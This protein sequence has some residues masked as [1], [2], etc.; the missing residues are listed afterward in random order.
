MLV[1]L[2]PPYGPSATAGPAVAEHLDH[3][4][5]NDGADEGDDNLLPQF[6]R[7][8]GPAV[9]DGVEDQPADDR[10]DQPH[11]DVSDEA[12]PSA[13]DHEAG[14]EAGDKT[15]DEPGDEVMTCDRGKGNNVHVIP[16]ISPSYPATSD[17]I[18]VPG[19]R[20]PKLHC[21]IDP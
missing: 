17:E 15:N 10:A 5:K 14:E 9:P 21:V 19:G 7:G 20:G 1:S 8:V 2:I 11:D 18:D 16:L 13:S 6:D 12:E 4:Q 3:E